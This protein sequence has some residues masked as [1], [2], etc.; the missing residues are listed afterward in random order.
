MERSRK[1]VIWPANLDSGKSRADGRLIPRQLAIPS[2]KLQEME[3]AA[4]ELRLSPEKAVEKSYPKTWWEK[5]GHMRVE[6][7]APK[8][9]I[10]RQIAKKIGEARTRTASS[11]TTAGKHRKK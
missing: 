11:A 3:N 5:S 1:I 7:I 8:S 4:R 6:N 2:P 9:E 10:A